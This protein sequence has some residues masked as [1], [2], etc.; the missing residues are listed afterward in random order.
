[1]TFILAGVYN[2]IIERDKPLFETLQ[3]VN[4][5]MTEKELATALIDEYTRLQRIK[6]AQNRDEEIDYQIKATKAK[7][8]ALGVVIEGLDK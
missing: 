6:S 7:L 8:E 4:D 5:C 2:D 3:E 1:M